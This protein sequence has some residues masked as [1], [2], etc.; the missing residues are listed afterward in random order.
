MKKNL[1]FSIKERL[2]P[3]ELSSFIRSYDI[4]GD[5]AII[6]VPEELKSQSPFIA[7]VIMQTQ[8]HVKTVLRQTSAVLGEY[9]LRQLEWIAGENKTETL[10]REFGCV[11]KV[12]LSRCYFSPRL[13]FERMRLA[14]LVQ[15]NETVVNMFAGV[16]TF[17]VLMAKHGGAQAVFSIDVNPIAVG[18]MRTNIRLNRVQSQVAPILGDAK[19]VIQGLKSVANRVTMPLPEKAFEYL[20]YAVLALKPTNGWIH[21]YDFEHASKKE[22]PIEKVKSKIIMKLHKLC[23]EFSVPFGKV[24]RSTGP[25]WHQVVLDIEVDQK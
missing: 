3:R 25:N 20:D 16:G 2:P 24:V 15:P 12:D 14:K 5:I 23:K 18:Y 8:K 9:R 11:F 7:E 6:R 4:I 21:Y 17:S 19:Q 10:H 22:D 13:S 1:K